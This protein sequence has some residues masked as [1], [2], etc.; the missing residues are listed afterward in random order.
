MYASVWKE[1]AAWLPVITGRYNALHSEEDQE[2]GVRAAGTIAI[3]HPESISSVSLSDESTVSNGNM[4]E[5]MYLPPYGISDSESE[6]PL[7]YE[8][9]EY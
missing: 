1:V 3:G 7:G 8:S 6:D 5:A 2:V 9:S 4:H